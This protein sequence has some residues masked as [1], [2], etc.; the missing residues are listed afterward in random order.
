M[1]DQEQEPV[2]EK[3][4]HEGENDEAQDE[5]DDDDNDDDGDHSTASRPDQTADCDKANALSFAMICHRLEKLW[6]LKRSKKKVSEKEKKQYLLPPK[7]LQSLE[8]QSIFPLLRL[9]LP[10]IDSA[11]NCFLKEKLIAQLYCAVEGFAKNTKHYNMLYNYTNPQL[12]PH[13]M[14]GDLSLVIQHVLSQRIPSTPSKATLG[15]INQ[16]LDELARLKRLTASSTNHEWR[17]TTADD[18][19]NNNDNASKK[20]KPSILSL[21]EEWLTK[22]QR[23]YRLSPLEHK[24]LVRI[25]LQKLEF[26][27][28]WRAVLGWY[29]PYSM[30]LWNAHNS[31]KNL[32]DTL[33]D[34]HYHDIRQHQEQLIREE[35]QQ[36]MNSVSRW[37]PQTQPAMLGCTI[38]PM[39]SNRVS[40]ANCMTQI[41]WNHV[42][43][44]KQQQQ[45]SWTYIPLSLK[46]PT[47]AV[48]LKVDGER[49][50]IHVAEDQTVTMHTRNGKWYSQLYSPVLGPAIRRAIS[51]YN[52][53]V[54][55]DGEVVAW[56]NGR[57]QVIP[58]GNNRTVANYRRSYLYHHK[59]LDPRDLNLHTS[60][61][62]STVDDS[63][64]VMQATDE[65]RFTKVDPKD[66]EAGRECWLQYMVF[67]ILYVHGPDATKL[68]QE[69][70]LASTID[71]SSNGSILH[72]STLERKQVLY[73]LIEEQPRQVEICPAVVIRSN[74]ECVSGSTY[75]ST[76]EPILMEGEY[77]ATVLDSTHATIQKVVPNLEL[78]DQQRR[79]SKS[80]TEISQLRAHAMD[81]FYRTVV[82][83]F[84]MEG[85]VIKDLAAPYILGGESRSRK[86]WQKFKP[87]YEKDGT[88]V[89]ID[90]LVLGAYFATGLRHSGKISHF[91]CGCIDSEDPTTFMTLCNV[92]GA[93]SQEEREQ[94]LQSTGFQ[95]ATEDNELDLGKWF[96]EEE[97]YQ[98]LPNF[99]SRRSLQR[100]REDYDG[101]KFSRNK[102][103]PDLWIH[104]ED[105][106]LLTIYGQELV[107]SEEYSAGLALRFARIQKMRMNG[108]EKSS[109]EICTDRDLWQLYLE[110]VK[111][112]QESTGM[113]TD[114]PSA[115]LTLGDHATLPCRFQTPEEYERRQKSKKRKK[116][117]PVSPSKVPKV[118]S[119]ESAALKG[120]SITVLEGL[121]SLDPGSLDAQEGK[122]E[123]WLEQA[124]TVQ[125]KEDVM[126]FVLLHGGTIKVAAENEGLIIGGTETDARVIHYMKGIEYARNQNI[127]KP[128][129]K[130]Q[131]QLQQMAQQE[132][133][134]KWTFLYSLVH[135]W[136]KLEYGK[137]RKGDLFD[138]GSGHEHDDGEPCIRLTFPALLQ[139]KNHH[140]LVRS[141][142]VQKKIGEEIFNLN[143]PD[144]VSLIDLKR[145]LEETTAGKL[146]V[147]CC[148]PWQYMGIHVMPEENR[149]ALACQHSVFWPYPSKGAG[150]ND[151][152][153]MVLY[154]DVFQSGFGNF[155]REQ[156]TMESLAGKKCARSEQVDDTCGSVL[157]ALPLAR[158]MGALISCHLHSGVTH[159]LCDLIDGLETVYF[160]SVN[161]ESFRNA[162]RGE[163]LVR[164]MLRSR[165]MCEGWSVL[166]MSPSFLRA[167]WESAR[168]KPFA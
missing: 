28:G 152:Q 93:V 159:I 38:S 104:P 24:W 163:S 141:K 49:M 166:L 136:L 52:V 88:A 46:F 63:I 74:G 72:L 107:P 4:I 36:A 59:L 14:A 40:F 113:M 10:D 79:R 65:T 20:K 55:L 99:I 9:I 156:A 161:V 42:E 39:L 76:T 137:K 80:V 57:Q 89:D 120:L 45:S 103:Y 64:Q 112:R 140:F 125:N 8:G 95:P 85:V 109:A 135:R 102:N 96:Q 149:W 123:G 160:D 139:P 126:K 43:Y 69:C 34:P 21:R 23:R 165:K 116:K 115:S 145:A 73:R 87:D 6:A 22:L 71:P 41:Q 77:P 146:E 32:C 117:T 51:N 118:E 47:V 31:L 29:S 15:D 19:N 168:R 132:G 37:Q 84:R 131:F 26:G 50:L 110:N 167:K 7:L 122:E 128:K 148:R 78:V 158:A 18:D 108:D 11:R 30:E 143:N 157:S 70:G 133:V 27:L 53:S 154:P 62:S 2:E 86:Y 75:F 100:G 35:E 127:E 150:E 111:Q 105:S 60:S 151:S 119:K 92:N 134:L 16:A 114:A 12:V 138:V 130:K 83:D 61:S 98:S 147:D 153:P 68:F 25:L 58:F 13:T 81:D 1:S 67:D 33:A 94:I 17:R 162:A 5:D 48:E 82:E 66:H 106:F 91:L 155:D 121:Y 124:L 54:I 97:H 129:T 144:P 90:V 3:F 164:Y 56:D 101:W 44:L 142:A